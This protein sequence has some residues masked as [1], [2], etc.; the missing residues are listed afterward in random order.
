MRDHRAPRHSLAMGARTQ[1][2]PSTLAPSQ[3]MVGGLLTERAH[4]QESILGNANPQNVSKDA[5]VRVASSY[6][7]HLGTSL[8][9][10]VR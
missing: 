3:L 4:L 1:C 8:L 5:H 7:K 9:V 2:P 10:K 6:K